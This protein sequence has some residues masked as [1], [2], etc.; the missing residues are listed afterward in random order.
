MAQQYLRE[1]AGVAQ[2]IFG[3]ELKNFIETH[4]PKKEMRIDMRELLRNFTY[5]EKKEFSEPYM[6]VRSL[7]QF[8]YESDSSDSDSDSDSDSESCANVQIKLSQKTGP[9]LNKILNDV[10][11]KDPQMYVILKKQMIGD[12]GEYSSL[13][14]YFEH[15]RQ[16]SA[17]IWEWIK[18]YTSPKK[19]I[20]ERE[21]NFHVRPSSSSL[22]GNPVSIPTIV[23]NIPQAHTTCVTALAIDPT[24]HILATGS[25]DNIV[26]LWSCLDPENPVLIKVLNGHKDVITSVVFIPTLDLVA[27]GS[28]DGTVILWD[29]L[30]PLNTEGSKLDLRSKV[31]SLAF[32]PGES[33]LAIATDTIT[34]KL[35]K[36]S[37][38][39]Q[40]IIKD[41]IGH[42]SF[43]TCV[44]FHPSL[45]RL[46]SASGLGYHKII[47]WD[48]SDP[49][50][51]TQLAVN[52]CI[53][54]TVISLAF[55][56]I[57]SFL[58]FGSKEDSFLKFWDY[59]KPK[60]QMKTLN[61][62]R[63]SVKVAFGEKLPRL[64]SASDDKT[65]ILWDCADP[66]NICQIAKWDVP[67]EVLSLD[68]HS[69]LLAFGGM[70]TT[71]KLLKYGSN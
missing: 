54:T 37:G 71:V 18:E 9:E 33:L 6:S 28:E 17:K 68:F 36:L 56:P 20:E 43:V 24:K 40:P 42:D 1:R 11:S 47:L 15:Q 19:K 53:T 25:R 2:G 5:E 26:K 34:V 48:C 41:L 21:Q 63:S 12:Y 22:F 69:P 13:D 49:E 57:N 32:K 30:D 65:I 7:V 45:P 64:V 8:D 70:S 62:H 39:Q 67:F 66:E 35:M 27:S 38:Q 52:R 14:V 60:V 16:W 51:T 4:I 44:A 58:A 10:F 23:G 50:N 55:N 31:R 29:C 46:A 3:K 59:S 61:C